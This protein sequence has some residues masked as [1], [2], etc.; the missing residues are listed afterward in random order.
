MHCHVKGI[1]TQTSDWTYINAKY[2]LIHGKPELANVHQ[3]HVEAR[4]D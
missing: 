1:L 2:I 3:Q 4:L